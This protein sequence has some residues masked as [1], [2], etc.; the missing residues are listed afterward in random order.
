ME[1]F[2]T[3]PETVTVTYGRDDGVWERSLILRVCYTRSSATA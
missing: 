2:R 3:A 1:T